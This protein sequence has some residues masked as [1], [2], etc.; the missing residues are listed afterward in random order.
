MTKKTPRIV[1]NLPI[2]PNHPIE[3]DTFDLNK[4][5]DVIHLRNSFIRSRYNSLQACNVP[6][7]ERIKH[8]SL[9]Y[10]S[11]PQNIERIITENTD[12]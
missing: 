11:S 4:A 6:Y 2:K 12:K 10:H 3:Q 5:Y 1:P 7:N 8:L 9:K